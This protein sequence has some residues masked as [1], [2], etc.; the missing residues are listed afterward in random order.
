VRAV[1]AWSLLSQAAERLAPSRWALLGEATVVSRMVHGHGAA[2]EAAVV[3]HVG[4]DAGRNLYGL[5]ESG[6]VWHADVLHT[7]GSCDPLR[8]RRQLRRAARSFLR[9]RGEPADET[10]R[11]LAWLEARTRTPGGGDGCGGTTP[12]HVHL[13]LRAGR[14][15][16]EFLPA[17]VEAVEEAILETGLALRRVPR[18]APTWDSPQR[19]PCACGTD[20]G[21][22]AAGVAQG[23][24]QPGGT[25]GPTA[26]SAVAAPGMAAALGDEGVAT[27]LSRRGAA[28]DGQAPAPRRAAGLAG[29]G[30]P[31]LPTPPPTVEGRALWA[32]TAWR[33][34][35][36]S[37]P[38]GGPWPGS[39]TTHPSA[40][41]NRRG[42]A[43]REAGAVPAPLATVATALRRD[44]PPA[45]VRPEDLRWQEPVPRRPVDVVVAL[46]RSPSMR[47]R[48]AAVGPLAEGLL[49]A[50][51]ALSVY[52]LPLAAG[53]APAGPII[54]PASRHRARV[55]AALRAL[56]T[57]TARG[58]T[59]LDAGIAALA[60]ALE[61]RLPARRLLCLLIT[62]GLATEAADGGDPFAAACHAMGRL[63]GIP[64]VR[65][66]VAGWQ[67]S[68]ARL[69]AL[70]AA[71]A[72]RFLP[73]D[74]PGAGRPPTA[75]AR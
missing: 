43:A 68:R 4:A 45:R 60:A 50:G 26:G 13:A 69:E 37:P 16:L 75:S 48:L 36:G 65:V 17:A 38:A 29:A 56:L 5:R 71:A 57:E 24:Q 20:L 10:Q 52:P 19:T 66:V 61:A 67:A 46:D 14:V 53:S 15:P 64:R 3:V 12:G 58:G 32:P 41:P 49:R 28:G 11:L 70:A 6:Q 42:A 62:D 31:G 23:L 7:P 72:A 54:P 44:G 2:G 35:A 27:P 33:R 74:A 22:A 73:L 59:A 51:H 8:L 63:R 34:A 9:A 21:P 47:Q 25:P 18:I 1:L 30:G 40:R 39:G 55:Q